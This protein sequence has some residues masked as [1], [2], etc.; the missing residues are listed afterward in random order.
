MD[1]DPRIKQRGHEIGEQIAEDNRERG[2]ERHAHD[3]RHIH[4]LDRLP[5]ELSDAGPTV[6]GLDHDDAAHELA[7][8]DPD[9][10]DDGKKRVR[11]RVP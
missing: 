6:D 8:V 2:H 10:R 3:D 4:F 1:A 5:G 7:N 11:Q 9:H